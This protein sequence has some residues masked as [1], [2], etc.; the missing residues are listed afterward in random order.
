MPL[1]P[2]RVLAAFAVAG[3]QVPLP[4]GTGDSVRVE[5]AVLKP[6]GD[7]VEANWLAELQD[8]LHVDGL[9]TPR[10]IRAT[11][12]RWVVDGWTA[13]TYLAGAE[14]PGRWSEVVDAARRLHA[15]LA[16]ISCPDF[17]AT[18]DHR[19]A[20]ADRI[21]WGEV[22]AD[23]GPVGAR[24]MASRRPLDLPRQLAHC[25][26]SGNVLFHDSKPPVVIDL[27]LYWRPAPYAEA[28]VAVDAL[29]WYGAGP[30]VLDLVDHP[31][32]TQLLVR[33]AIFRLACEGAPDHVERTPI[34][35]YERLADLLACP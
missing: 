23:L 30:D 11:D 7:E 14:Q 18:R 19:W 32:A 27:S 12:G 17:L 2:E 35:E 5:N 20:V 3:H 1:V 34:R 9:R 8:G 6:A 4:G 21:A 22:S 25:D 16:G 15:A 28:V 10:P 13:T 33:A 26:L 24:L 29:L 31:E